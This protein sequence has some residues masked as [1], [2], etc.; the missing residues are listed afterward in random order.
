[1]PLYRR[2]DRGPAVAEIRARLAG[3]GLLDE[4]ADRAIDVFD[5]DADRAVRGFQ[6]SRGLSVDGIVGADTYRA[7]DEAR[8]RLGHRLLTFVPGHPSIGDD[9]AELQRRLLDL[10][11]DPGRCDGIYGPR[12]AG[13]VRDFQRNVGLGPDGSCGPRTLRA[14]NQLARAVVGGSPEGM[15]EEERL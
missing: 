7:L 12:T 4:P 10:G 3:L 2:G 1:M 11:F 5:D 8:W 14:L 9:V 15:R 6:Q 13:A